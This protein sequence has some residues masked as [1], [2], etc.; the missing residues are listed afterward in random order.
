MEWNERI[1]RYPGEQY[2]CSMCICDMN[3]LGYTYHLR[4]W[5]DGWMNKLMKEVHSRDLSEAVRMQDFLRIV[6]WIF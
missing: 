2:I 1:I 3:K 5:M 4:V 6:I